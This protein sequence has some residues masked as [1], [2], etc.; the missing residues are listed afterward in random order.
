[1]TSKPTCV[2]PRIVRYLGNGAALNLLSMM[3]VAIAGVACSG[4]VSKYGVVVSSGDIEEVRTVLPNN[5]PTI[6][7]G[8]HPYPE[9]RLQ[10]EPPREHLGLDILADAGTSVLAAAD[11][12]VLAS[13][14]EPA[15]GN[16]IAI[17]HG[18]D[19]NGQLIV[20]K[21]FH[22]QQRL[23]VKG[24]RV[25]RGQRIGQLGKTGV[26]AGGLLHLHYELHRQTD[27]V[28][29]GPIDPQLYW[30]DGPGRVVC[31]SRGREWPPAPL[32]MTYPVVCLGENP[33]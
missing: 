30:V 7:R 26:L 31:F 19:E 16:R 33:L 23:V 21:Y 6:W 10:R 4:G 9:E 8:F 17:D 15:Y 18:E 22:L 29:L 25:S 28:D 13:F 2:I 1:M 32:R 3:A 12:I 11:G 20:T 5:A 24:E 27:G 14:F